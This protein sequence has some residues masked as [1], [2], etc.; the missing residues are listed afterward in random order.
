MG[1]LQRPI[2]SV[3]IVR[4]RNNNVS[5]YSTSD[6]FNN[7]LKVKVFED[8][9]ELQVATLQSRK[10]RRPTKINNGYALHLCAQTKLGVFE[11]DPEESNED[12]V[13]I[14]CM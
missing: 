7:E 10:S 8:R 4:I 14:Y 2:N 5:I 13:V 6:F 1:I 12:K 3:N 9:I 11:F